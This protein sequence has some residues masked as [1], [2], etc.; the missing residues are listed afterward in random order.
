MK[1]WDSVY[2]YL[3]VPSK[4]Y[5]ILTIRRSMDIGHMQQRA[6]GVL[7]RVVV[8]KIADTGIKFHHAQERVS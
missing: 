2:T 1:I 6:M 5:H 7:E 8:C 4:P 3:T